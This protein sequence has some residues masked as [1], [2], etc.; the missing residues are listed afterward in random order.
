MKYLK[1]YKLFEKNEIETLD[2]VLSK[3]MSEEYPI[4][5]V[6]NIIKLDKDDYEIK[7]NPSKNNLIIEINEDKLCFYLGV[8]DKTISWFENLSDQ[9]NDYSYQFDEDEYG[10]L[11]Y[12]LNDNSKD[13][14]KELADYV[15]YDIDVNDGLKIKKMFDYLGLY[16]ISYEI[17]EKIIETK[18][19]KIKIEAEKIIENLPFKI[20]SDFNQSKEYSIIFNY[21]D[22]IEYI[23]EH[24]LTDVYSF[25]TF[26][27]RV[28]N[29]EKLDFTFEKNINYDFDDFET[30]NDC[31]Y[32]E[33]G[34]LIDDP[35][36]LFGCI[37]KK[38][39]LKLLKNKIEDI[40]FTDMTKN[41][42]KGHIVYSDYYLFQLAEK[43]GK[44]YNWFKTYDLQKY[45]M[46]KFDEKE[47]FNIL[48]KCDIINDKILNEYKYIDEGE[49]MGFFDLKI[50]EKE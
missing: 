7:T 20:D 38:D 13:T 43:D 8:E 6:D 25:E 10:D 9:F 14:I 39:N 22:V 37:V 19:S 2:V 4:M 12:Y 33:I 28:G 46:E 23:K 31:V 26:L 5:Y 27:N 44:V 18:T 24:N 29:I 36:D 42:L 30:L 3:I 35:I 41:V 40:D 49:G 15:D 47:M 1:T 17:K 50:K 48:K 21:K 45:M 32:D 11:K 34:E 16:D